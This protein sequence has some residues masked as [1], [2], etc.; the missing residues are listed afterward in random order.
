MTEG[1]RHFGLYSEELGLSESAMK[2]ALDAGGMIILALGP[3]DFTTEGHFIL[4]YGYGDN[5]FR[6]NDPN[7]MERSNRSWTYTELSKQIRNL[8]AVYKK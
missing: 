3:G 8:W 7:S 1:A 6:L 4:V 5:G 2:S